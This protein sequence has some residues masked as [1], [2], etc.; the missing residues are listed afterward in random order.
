MDRFVGG[1][2]GMDMDKTNTEAIAASDK[3]RRRRTS[4]PMGAILLQVA[5]WCG[6]VFSGF[7]YM[8]N[9]LAAS[10]ED[11]E[12]TNALQVR[13]LEERL[14]V[15]QQQLEEIEGVLMAADDSLG[16]SSA[17]QEELSARINRLD[18]QLERLEE[19]L[20]ILQEPDGS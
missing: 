3:R 15:V 17:T 12:Q 1:K 20:T 11:L 16:Q 19:S 8:D 5:L 4:T 10:L 2:G 6:L 9:H 7:Y 13:V 18:R 14:G